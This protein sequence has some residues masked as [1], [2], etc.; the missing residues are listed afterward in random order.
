MKYMLFKI[1]G[2][3]VISLLAV[4]TIL[5]L[6][7]NVAGDSL[8][9]FAAVAMAFSSLLYLFSYLPLIALRQLKSFYG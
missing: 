4:A 6:I 7:G 1:F 8:L 5:K 9:P 3:T 2:I